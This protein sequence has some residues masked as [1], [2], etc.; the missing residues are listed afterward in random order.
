MRVATSRR[1]FSAFLSLVPLA[2]S[3]ATLR[4]RKFS[5]AMLN[6]S[7]RASRPPSRNPER[8][9]PSCAWWAWFEVKDGS[10]RCEKSDCNSPGDK[11]EG[12]VRV[13]GSEVMGSERISCLSSGRNVSSV[14]GDVVEEAAASGIAASWVVAVSVEV[15][16]PCKRQ[17]VQRALSSSSSQMQS[18]MH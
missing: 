7:A 17:S 5:L 14:C 18:V 3:T 1:L 12:R 15:C 4:L 10:E 6:V 13:S 2:P 11:G 8:T 9:L 16:N